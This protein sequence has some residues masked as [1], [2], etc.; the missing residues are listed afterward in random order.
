VAAP[1]ELRLHESMLDLIDKA[2]GGKAVWR[3]GGAPDGS[4]MSH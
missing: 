4:G 3:T 2:S 1:E